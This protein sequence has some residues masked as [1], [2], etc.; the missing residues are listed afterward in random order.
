MTVG[1][2]PSAPVRWFDTHVHLERYAPAEAEGLMTRAAAAGVVGLLAVSTSLESSRRTLALPADV[3]RAVG[4]HP[5]EAAQGVAG[6]EALAAAP[7]VVAI[8]E[9]GFD[10]AGPALASQAA[11]FAAQCALA[12]ARDLAVILHVDAAW[13]QFLAHGDEL[14]GLRVIRHYFRGDAAQAAWHA[15]RGHYLSFGR[16]LLRDPALAAIAASYPPDLLLIET[17]TY[18]VPGRTTEPRDLVA[19]GEALARARAWSLEECAARLWANSLRALALTGANVP[20]PG[21]TS[22]AGG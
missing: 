10:A 22:A 12:R 20:G 19:G 14:D 6:L 11:A 13:E 7:G 4:V 17:D 21:P 5:L 16:P 8:G 1:Q 3:P 18:P 9:T 2:Q 15:E